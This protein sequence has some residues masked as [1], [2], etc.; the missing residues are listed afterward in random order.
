MYIRV[1]LKIGQPNT[2]GWSD[3]HISHDSHIE[4]PMFRHCWLCCRAWLRRHCHF[5]KYT[6]LSS[7]EI[8]H[9]FTIHPYIYI[10]T[11]IYIYMHTYCVNIYIYI[12]ILLYANVYNHSCWQL[13]S[14]RLSSFITRVRG[15][16]RYFQISRAFSR[17][18]DPTSTLSYTSYIRSHGPG[19]AGSCPQRWDQLTHE[20]IGKVMKI[21]CNIYQKNTN[22]NG[23]PL[24]WWGMIHWPLNSLSPRAPKKKQ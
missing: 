19:F 22:G 16:P 4:G 13:K 9:Q 23:T 12:Y 1:C 5:C 20:T 14:N 17:R 21:Q 7:L 15:Y 3:H 8:K 11:Y 18:C 10:H 24:F 6:H 2:K